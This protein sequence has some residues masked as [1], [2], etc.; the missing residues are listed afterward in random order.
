MAAGS[1]DASGA[2]KERKMKT[3]AG[4]LTACVLTGVGTSVWTANAGESGTATN[5][6]QRIEQNKEKR[7]ARFNEHMAK[8]Q[9][10]HAEAVAKLKER[11]ANNK[12]LTDEEKQEIVNFFE[13]QYK[14]NREFRTAQHEETMQFLNSLGDQSDLTKEQVKEKIKAFVDQQKAENKEHREKQKEERKAERAK[15]KGD[16]PNAKPASE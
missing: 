2:G 9:Q 16:P 11:L 12:R 4:I 7:E 6:G 8:W 5:A 15:F 14:E 3:M 1:N 13:Q 10:K